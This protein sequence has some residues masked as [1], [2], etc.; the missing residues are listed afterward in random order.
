MSHVIKHETCPRCAANGRDRTGDNLAI[1]DD[2]GSYCFSCGYFQSARG[3]QSIS[4]EATGTAKT[5]TIPYDCTDR[6]PDVGREFLARYSIGEYDLALNNILWSE[7][8]QRLVFP[9]IV[10]GELLAWQGRYLGTEPKKAKWFTQGEI[11]KITYILGNPYMEDL[12]LVEDILSAIKISTTGI[13]RAMPIFGSHISAKRLL[14]IKRFCGMEIT[15]WLDRD[16]AKE[17]VGF[18]YLAR[19]LGL[20]A[21][22]VITEKDPKE[23]SKQEIIEIL[24]K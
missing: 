3:F 4:R 15:I 22:T 23:Y 8:Y 6:I 1:Y 20:K 21:R 11:D 18:A 7:K 12:I 10:E 14:T 17:A 24:D 9:I 19:N 5:L 16:K 2:G 13:H